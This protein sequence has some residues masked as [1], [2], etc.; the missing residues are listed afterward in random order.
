[1]AVELFLEGKMK[2]TQI[3]DSISYAVNTVKNI[4][5]PTLKQIFEADKEAR[6]IVLN[7]K[8]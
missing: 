2:Y 6:E 1:M 8:E 4:E 5:N 3:S 7:W